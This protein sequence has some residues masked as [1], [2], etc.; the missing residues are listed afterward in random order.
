VSHQGEGVATR[1]L[2]GLLIAPV[3]LIV[4][5]QANSPEAAL[6]S[7][8][9]PHT[10]QHGKGTP[11]DEAIGELTVTGEHEDGYDREAFNHWIDADDDCL[12]TRDEVL[13]AES[14]TRATGGECDISTGQWFSY[15]DEQ[16]WT[17]DDDLDIDHVVAL[18]EVW[19]SGAWD[20]SD[21]QRE[22]YANDLADPRTLVAVT[23]SVNRS[24]SDQDPAD[25]LPKENV[26]VRVGMGGREDPVATVHRPGRARGTGRRGCR[27]PGHGGGTGEGGRHQTG[28]DVD[29]AAASK[30]TSSTSDTGEQ[31]ESQATNQSDEEY[32]F[33]ESPDLDCSEIDER[34]FKVRPGDPHGFDSDGNGIG[35]ED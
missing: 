17:S 3:L 21:Q 35:C 10:G 1:T 28:P 33:P 4:A 15:Y 22:A 34:G 24:K 14:Q 23:N 26:S 9:P 27:L 19:R 11:L 13:A 5:C 16:T 6:P 2:R 31:G 12:D 25:W 8:A 30:Q 20:W 18:G 32:L 29:T 7:E